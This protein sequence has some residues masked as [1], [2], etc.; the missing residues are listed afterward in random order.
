MAYFILKDRI[1]VREYDFDKW[2]EWYRRSSNVLYQN[3]VFSIPIVTLFI[4]QASDNDFDPHLFVTVVQGQDGKQTIYKTWE[5][6][7]KG[8][9][10]IATEVTKTIVINN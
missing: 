2:R 6:A 5:D 9:I 1:P 4:G 3:E 10:I 7:L 8:H